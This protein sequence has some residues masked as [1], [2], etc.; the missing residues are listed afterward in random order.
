MTAPVRDRGSDGLPALLDPSISPVVVIEQGGDFDNVIDDDNSF[1]VNVSWTVAPAQ[2]AILL[3]G[4]WT[5]R[6]YVESVG[7]G[8]EVLAGQVNVQANGGQTYSASL[9]VPQGALPSNANPALNSGVY[10]VV[11]VL[12]YETSLGAKTQLTAF[13]EGP[14]F[15]I[16]TP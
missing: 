8:P 4:Q 2:T 3:T 15:M 11:T 10:K 12:T 14:H 6:A 7:P 9:L 1:R 13:S 5:V 16:R